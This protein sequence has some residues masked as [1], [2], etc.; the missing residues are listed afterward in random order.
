[1]RAFRHIDLK[2]KLEL[3]ASFPPLHEDWRDH[4]DLLTVPVSIWDHWLIS[5]GSQALL[6]EAT[7]AEEQDWNSRFDRLS[8]RMLRNTEVLYIHWRKHKELPYYKSVRSL[9]AATFALS[10]RNGYMF[11]LA[12]PEFLAFYEL[13]FDFTAFFHFL[14]PDRASTLIEWAED[15]G[16]KVVQD[17][18]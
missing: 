2:K 6:N 8:E 12:L 15:C 16:L 13:R 9:P 17:R 18:A 5:S 14:Q 1:M 7:P 11:T 10:S 3:A 4:P